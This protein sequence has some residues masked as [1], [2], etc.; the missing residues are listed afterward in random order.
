MTAP[1]SGKVRVISYR[2]HL[3]MRILAVVTLIGPVRRDRNKS[4][5]AHTMTIVLR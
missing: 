1:E 3:P 2:A 4:L 5:P